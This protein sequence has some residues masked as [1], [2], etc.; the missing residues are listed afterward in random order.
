[1]QIPLLHPTVFE[2]FKFAIR[3]FIHV[4]GQ[5]FLS[6]GHIYMFIGQIRKTLGLILYFA[7]AWS[8]Y[9]VYISN[10]CLKTSYFTC[11]HYLKRHRK[12][13]RSPCWTLSGIDFESVHSNHEFETLVDMVHTCTCTFLSR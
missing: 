4:S 8:R 1:M 9:I 6:Y 5:V 10:T 2:L 13:T 11:N 3:I 12:C 7:N